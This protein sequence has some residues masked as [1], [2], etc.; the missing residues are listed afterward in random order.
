MFIVMFMDNDKHNGEVFIRPSRAVRMLSH[1]TLVLA[2]SVIFVGVTEALSFFSLLKDGLIH[3]EVPV[4]PNSTQQLLDSWAG[5][6]ELAGP[7]YVTVVVSGAAYDLTNAFTVSALLQGTLLLAL[8]ALA[9][10]TAVAALRHRLSWSVLSKVIFWSGAAI[11]IGSTFV[12]ITQRSASEDLS[13]W[14]YAEETAWVEPGF[15]SGLNFLPIV[16][17]VCLL[18][19]GWSLRLTRRFAEEA[20]GVV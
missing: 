11:A 20:D 19:V 6:P 10:A 14:L 4:D 13:V 1:L 18:G 17:G 16:V 2:V 8:S 9:I 5:S 12:Q 15:L 7:S 3:A